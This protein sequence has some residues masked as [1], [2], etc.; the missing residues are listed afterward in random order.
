MGLADRLQHLIAVQLVDGPDIPAHQV[1]V[2]LQH[3][4]ELAGV[5]G[6]HQEEPRPAT[7]KR[8]PAPLRLGEVQPRSLLL[9]DALP[10]LLG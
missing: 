5:I 7:R 3:L 4:R 6:L 9:Q 2:G 1:D 8:V 10:R